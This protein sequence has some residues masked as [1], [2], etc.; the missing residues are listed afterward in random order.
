MLAHG[1]ERSSTFETGLEV[2]FSAL[3]GRGM[4]SVGYALKEYVRPGA[5]SDLGRVLS[6]F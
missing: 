2:Q 4:T 5:E 6:A 3:L 1:S